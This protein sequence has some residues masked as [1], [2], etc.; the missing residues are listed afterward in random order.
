MLS[1]LGDIPQIQDQSW[2]GKGKANLVR[3]IICV[4]WQI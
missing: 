2:H 1:N 3:R 4:W